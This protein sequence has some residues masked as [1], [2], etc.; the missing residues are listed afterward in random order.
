MKRVACHLHHESDILKNPE[1]Y[2][3]ASE[4]KLV[5]VMPGLDIVL[6]G[7][8][9]TEMKMIM[10]TEGVRKLRIRTAKAEYLILR[11]LDMDKNRWAHI[12][13]S[14]VY[15]FEKGDPDWMYYVDGDKRHPRRIV[16]AANKIGEHIVQGVRH[17]CPLMNRTCNLIWPN[18]EDFK[19]AAEVC[20]DEGFVD[21]YAKYWTRAQAL[22]IAINSKQIIR[23]GGQKN[24][25]WSENLY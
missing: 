25:L 16:S 11:N 20:Y 12:C 4:I 1:W 23:E 6:H 22:D 9:I 10:D 3:W 13:G 17:G 8:E 14:M 21:Q 5:K 24:W 7:S 2:R 15:G 19:A 18:E